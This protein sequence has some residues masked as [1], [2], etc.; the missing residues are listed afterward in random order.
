VID[1]GALRTVGDVV[2]APPL[3]DYEAVLG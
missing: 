2:E 1:L 3:A